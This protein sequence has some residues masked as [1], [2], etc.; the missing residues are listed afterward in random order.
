MV[1]K[2]LNFLRFDA[3]LQNDKYYAIIKL[4]KHNQALHEQT[5]ESVNPIRRVR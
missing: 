4:K 1:Q 5:C 2:Y 3:H